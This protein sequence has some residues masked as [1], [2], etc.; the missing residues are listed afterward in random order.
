MSGFRKAE[1]RPPDAAEIIVTIM[2]LGG[3]LLRGANIVMVEPPL[4]KSQPTSKKMVP[5]TTKGNELI[6][7]VSFF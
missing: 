5:K 6:S 4:K 2:I 7:N 3:L 1:T